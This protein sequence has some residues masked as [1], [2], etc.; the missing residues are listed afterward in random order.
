MSTAKKLIQKLK[1]RKAKIAVIGLGYVGLPLAI[2]KAKA[3]FNVV[4]IDRNIERVNKVNQGICYI[5]DVV[6]E[7][8][9]KLVKEGK[10]KAVNNFKVLKNIDAI[11]ICVPT[12]LNERREPDISYIKYVTKQIA[13]YLHKGQLVSL[14]STTYPGTTEEIVLPELEKGGLKVGK[15]F[16]LCFSPER[17]DPG[18]KQFKLKNTPKVVGGVTK[19]CSLV[20]KTLYSQIIDN[21]QIVSNPKVAEMEK[22]LENVFRIVNIALVDELAMLC[23]K[24]KINIWEVIDTAATK[25]Y[26]FMPFYPGPGIGGHCIPLDP[27][28][29]SWKAKE[30]GFKTEFIELAS[31]ISEYMPSYIIELL[32]DALSKKGKDIRYA[33]ILVLGVAYKKDINDWRES[34]SLKIIELLEERKAKVYYNDPYIPSVKI[35][36]KIW[37]SV[38]M[39]KNLIKSVDCVLIATDH[40]CYSY[41]DIIKNAKLILDTR[42]ITRFYNKSK[43]IIIL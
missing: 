39:T 38:Q 19:T 15:D 31:R 13:K 25:P 10:L 30:Y 26:G 23:R 22:L 36:G 35:G 18:N 8:M 9:D 11:C 40:S 2:E 43:K 20:A 24:M 33:K 21:V 29:L 1:E 16:F 12:P 6:E 3:G 42:G 4:G 28:Y 34:P 27:I 14:E 17:V 32:I 41:N 37:K 7:G 5:P